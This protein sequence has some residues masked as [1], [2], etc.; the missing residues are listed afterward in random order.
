LLLHVVDASDPSHEEH[1]RTVLR[2]LGD[3]ELSSIPRVVVFN[4][5]DAAR[6]LALRALRHEYPDAELV[7]AND[8][9]TT[10]SLIDRVARELAEKWQASAKGPPLLPEKEA[11]P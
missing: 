11:V 10:R 4:K 2:V 1:V 6:P 3:L 8:R 7:C 9:E 5:I